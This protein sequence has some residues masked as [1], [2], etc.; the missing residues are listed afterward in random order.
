LQAE[1]S[2]PSLALAVL[3]HKPVY[4]ARGIYKLLLAGKQRVTFRADIYPDTRLCGAGVYHFS[5]GADNRTILVF[6]VDLVF[7]FSLSLNEQTTYGV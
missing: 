1:A 3:F 6:G 2:R 7:H 5:A 4:P